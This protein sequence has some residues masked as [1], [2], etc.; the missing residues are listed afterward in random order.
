MA[1]LAAAFAALDDARPPGIPAGA[2]PET[3]TAPESSAMLAGVRARAAEIAA[4]HQ[5]V[6]DALTQAALQ[7]QALE[8]VLDRLRTGPGPAG[9]GGVPPPV[10]GASAEGVDR[11][12]E[13][14]E[15]LRLNLGSA[16]GNASAALLQQ[17]RATQALQDR[18]AA[19]PRGTGPAV[20]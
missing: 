12:L 8:R 11:V 17:R 9:A 3:G 1:R 10:P 5:R 2:A 16:I 6:V 19:D 7:T 14:L 15:E 20:D 4:W 13:E 18:L